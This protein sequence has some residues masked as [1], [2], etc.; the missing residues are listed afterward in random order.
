[1]TLAE[2]FF[3]DRA[4]ARI[5]RWMLTLA[6]IGTVAV[7]F[8]GGWRWSAGF[9][10][11]SLVSY[12]SFRGLQR[13]AQSLGPATEAKPPRARVAILMGVRYLLLAAG[14]YAIVRFSTLSLT[15]ALLGLFVSAAAVILEILY[16]LIYART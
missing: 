3:Y 4:L 11:G 5:V 1:M 16:E 14:G 7:W 8:H 13:V 6:A 9:L 10:A 15:A 12:L 2:P